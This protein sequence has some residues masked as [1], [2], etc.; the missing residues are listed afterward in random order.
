MAFGKAQTAAVPAGKPTFG[1]KPA[2]AP[3]AKAVTPASSGRRISLKPSDQQSGGILDDVD[4]V[5]QSALFTTFD[6]NGQTEP[7]LSLKVIF[8]EKDGKETEQHFSAGKL[9]H[10]VPTADGRGVEAAVGSNKTGLNDNCNAALFLKSIVDMGFPEDKIDEAGS[11]TEVFEGTNVH[12]NAVAQKKRAGL[13]AHDDKVRTILLVTKINEFPWESG[14]EAPASTKPAAKGKLA[15][16]PSKAPAAKANAAPAT[17]GGADLDDEAAAAILQVLEA[18]GGAVT[19][20]MLGMKVFRVLGQSPNRSPILNLC[21]SDDFLG[22]EGAP[23]QFDGTT[24]AA[25]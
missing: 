13:A 20:K 2:P 1:R 25:L 12:L 8:V 19:K 6:Y 4:V 15:T 3:A 11:S 24:V 21:G 5:I 9:E 23:W 18:E 16:V 14:Q 17:N 7:G 10:M 22:Q